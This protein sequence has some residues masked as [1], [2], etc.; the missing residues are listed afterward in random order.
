ME[1]LELFP[2]PT[3]GVLVGMTTA[4]SWSTGSDA[5]PI[6]L[7]YVATDSAD[8]ISFVSL[9]TAPRVEDVLCIACRPSRLEDM[10]YGVVIEV[11]LARRLTESETVHVVLA[12]AGAT[13]YYPP[14]PI[15]DL[16]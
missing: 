7:A 10:P 11:H 12:Q 4:N 14:Q 9:Q 6:L 13:T 5:L 2:M 15:D 3:Q 8:R 16:E 1:P